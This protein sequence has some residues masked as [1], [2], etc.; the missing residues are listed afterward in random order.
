VKQLQDIPISHKKDFASQ[1]LSLG[2]DLQLMHDGGEETARE[3]DLL[4]DSHRKSGESGDIGIT[5]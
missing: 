3:T 5:E 1:L 2:L 4:K